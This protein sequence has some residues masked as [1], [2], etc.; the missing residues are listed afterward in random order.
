MTDQTQEDSDQQPLYRQQAY[1]QRGRVAP[2]DG[3]LRVSAPREWL[4]LIIL[5]AVV[6]AVIAW[7]V[8]GRLESGISAACALRAAGE[9]HVVAAPASGV[10]TEVLVEPG[11]QVSA[12][13]PLVRVAAPEISLAAEVAE[14]RAAA[15]VA[16]HPGSPEAAGAAAEAEVLRAA[17]AAGTLVLSPASGVLAPLVVSAGTAVD[18]G[19]A[20]AEV[21]RF[22]A[23][24]PTVVLAVD[25]SAA[26]RTAPSAAVSVVITSA[27]ETEVIG[28]DARLSGASPGQVPEQLSGSGAFSAAGA[29]LAAEFDDPPAALGALARQSETAY[30]CEARI[31]T[32]SRRPIQ[33]L[34]GR[35]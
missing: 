7:S 32:D 25:S 14:A 33:M 20:V 8:L 18:P 17:E 6:A 16:Q 30:A 26:A 15:V 9:R 13:D 31:V 28:A 21:L 34:I 22:G 5:A 29:L 2:I 12:G 27:G 19:S 3:I 23:G 11:R 4:M 10:V 35:G 1:Q 24:P